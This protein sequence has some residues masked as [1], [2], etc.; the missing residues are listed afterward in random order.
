[1]TRWSTTLIGALAL[2]M[3]ALACT[4]PIAFTNGTTVM[5]EYGAGTMEEA[6]IFYAP[7][8][9]YSVGGGH[10]EFDSDESPL[11][12]RITY[13]RLNYLAHRWNKEDSQAN[14]FAW[15]GVGAATRL[16]RSSHGPASSVTR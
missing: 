6:Q 11:T 2:S 7:R 16:C 12:E 8:Y 3:P 10:V 5:A 15:G 1:M 13:V 9:D 4:K 14:I